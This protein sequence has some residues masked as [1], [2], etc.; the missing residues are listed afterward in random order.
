M[1]TDSVDIA[2]LN[3]ALGQNENVTRSSASDI[4]KAEQSLA[5]TLDAELST[6][7]KCDESLKRRVEVML[8]SLEV[9]NVPNKRVR[10]STDQGIQIDSGNPL[11]MVNV[12]L[13]NSAMESS[14][15]S[16]YSGIN[17]NVGDGNGDDSGVS[18][19]DT[20]DS[21][22]CEEISKQVGLGLQVRKRGAR[23]LTME[24][25]E[26]LNHDIQYGNPPLTI[27]Q[28][29]TKYNVPRHIPGRRERF[30]RSKGVS[31][32]GVAAANPHNAP[33]KVYPTDTGKSTHIN[34]NIISSEAY[35]A[36][37]DDIQH[38]NPPK[39]QTALAAKHGVSTGVIRRRSRA[40]ES[41][42]SACAGM[43]TDH[44]SKALYTP[45]VRGEGNA[46]VIENQQLALQ[47]QPQKQEHKQQERDTNSSSSCS[48]CS[49]SCALAC[50]IGGRNCE[51]Q[52]RG[53]EEPPSEEQLAI[54]TV[55]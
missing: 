5:T 11:Q 1:S 23:V 14:N 36:I 47:K 3:G 30:M 35:A 24:E 40:L 53:I 54:G 18:G 20:F 26:A 17:D 46:P 37:D 19:D 16:V 28:L 38:A 43:C 12:D 51:L 8:C 9:D 33:F 31:T 4:G 25:S 42:G 48:S 34:K 50:C 32:A 29:A 45:G 6:S 52:L 2:V 13:M 55:I 44:W 21:K 27:T 41:S 15:E 7:D 22:A 39:T 10:C 49:S